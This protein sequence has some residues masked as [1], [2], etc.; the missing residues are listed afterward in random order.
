MKLSKE[1]FNQLLNAILE[2]YHDINNLEI[3]V[4]TDLGENLNAIAGG[5]NNTQKVFK[6]IEWAE[7]YGKTQQLLEALQR[8]VLI[9]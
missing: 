5:D 7:C 3:L 8:I 1:D 4:R 9:I 2:S 6:L